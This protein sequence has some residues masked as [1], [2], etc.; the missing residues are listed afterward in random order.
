MQPPRATQPSWFDP[1]AAPLTDEQTRQAVKDKTKVYPEVIRSNADPVLATQGFGLVSFLLFKEPKKLKNGKPVYGFV[2]LRGNYASKDQCVM[3]GTKIVKFVDSKSVNRIAPV[4][5]YVPIV[6]DD[7]FTEEQVDVKTEE[8]QM[9]AVN[10]EKADETRRIMREIRER[11]EECKAGDIY[12]NPDTLRFYSM[13]R[14]TEMKLTEEIAN[15]LK[16]IETLR[17]TN[18]K[19]RAELYE[20]EKKHSEYE[21]EWLECYNVERRKAGIPDFIP[22]ADQFNEYDAFRARSKE[23]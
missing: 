9:H 16:Q 2:K 18:E 3:E 22:A 4:G 8:S 15:R 19:V 14:V 11:E 23:T 20:L 21:K 6:D 10:Q 1:S 7:V 13:R 5:R 12:D 17:T